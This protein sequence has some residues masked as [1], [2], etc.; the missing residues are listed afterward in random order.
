MFLN[1]L[2]ANGPLGVDLEFGIRENVRI[3]RISNE[4]VLRDG[5]PTGQGCFITFREY[6]AKDTNK[7]MMESKFSYFN[8]EA[9]HERVLK[10]LSSKLGQLQ[11]IVNVLN[12]GVVVDPTEVFK[13]NE[14]AFA[15]ALSTKEGCASI[16]KDMFDQF[17]SAV[18]GKIGAESKLCRVKIVTDKSGVYSRLPYDLT[19]MEGMDTETTLGITPF[20]MK[21]KLA[22]AGGEVAASGVVKSNVPGKGITDLL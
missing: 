6:D 5:I 7:G 22:A 13:G 21:N 4:V 17:A 2:L 10:T 11:N 18:K 16:D 3:T 9:G 8:L 19:F 14:D 1:K 12:P 20:E 15:A